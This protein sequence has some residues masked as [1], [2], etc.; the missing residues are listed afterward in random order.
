MLSN[1]YMFYESYCTMQQ[2]VYDMSAWWRRLLMWHTKV[3][4][5]ATMTQRPGL[6]RKHGLMVAQ[7]LDEFARWRAPVKRWV[8]KRMA[9]DSI[10]FNITID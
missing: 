6:D 5:K 4:R 9:A 2:P 7:K 3:L 1:P 10:V 8:T